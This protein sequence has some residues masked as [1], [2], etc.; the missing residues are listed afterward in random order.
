M[1]TFV[2]FLPFFL[3]M[4]T[5]LPQDPAAYNKAAPVSGEENNNVDLA[6][7]AW[8]VTASNGAVNVEFYADKNP[9]DRT[10]IDI[11]TCNGKAEVALMKWRSHCKAFNAIFRKSCYTDAPGT[12][13]C[14]PVPHEK[15]CTHFWPKAGE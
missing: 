8:N 14:C 13:K 2:A 6:A 4:A 1:K 7:E 9:D 12:N 11:N 15:S 10:K 3:S 5:A